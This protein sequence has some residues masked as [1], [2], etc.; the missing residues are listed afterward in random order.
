[1]NAELRGARCARA[2]VKRGVGQTGRCLLAKLDIPRA[3][4]GK[5]QEEEEEEEV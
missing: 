1:M 5:A 3:P 2:S 4:G